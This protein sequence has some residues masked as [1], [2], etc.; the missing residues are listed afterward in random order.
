MPKDIV[1]F[2][3]LHV[4]GVITWLIVGE[5][6]FKDLCK[7]CAQKSKFPSNTLS[8]MQKCVC[9]MTMVV[10]GLLGFALILTCYPSFFAL[11]IARNTPDISGANAIIAQIISQMPQMPRL[12][13]ALDGL[14]VLEKLIYAVI[15]YIW[16]APAYQ[17]A[18]HTGL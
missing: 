14:Y 5:H 16:G 6:G 2:L 11:F 13:L 4:W 15:I 1:L 3:T 9:D 7:W 10:T 17:R 12:L 8:L 18:F